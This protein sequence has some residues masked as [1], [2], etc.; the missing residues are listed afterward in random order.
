MNQNDIRNQLLW[1]YQ[2]SQQNVPFQNN[3]LLQQNPMFRDN[4]NYNN[5]QQLQMMQNK[6][7]KSASSH[8]NKWFVCTNDGFCCVLDRKGIAIYNVTSILL[9]YNGRVNHGQIGNVN[10]HIGELGT[11]RRKVGTQCRFS[12]TIVSTIWIGN[13][14]CIG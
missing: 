9:T 14:R 6:C 13:H 12:G 11:H 3:S 2:N 10:I 7:S 8:P 5:S 1:K 4:M